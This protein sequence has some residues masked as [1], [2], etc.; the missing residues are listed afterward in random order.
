MRGIFLIYTFNLSSHWSH[1]YVASL[2]PFMIYLEIRGEIKSIL[3][4]L[5]W[6]GKCC[7]L[8]CLSVFHHIYTQ[9]EIK[10]ANSFKNKN[11]RPHE[12]FWKLMSIFPLLEKNN[13]LTRTS[14]I[15]QCKPSHIIWVLSK[16]W[17]ICW[18]KKR[19]NFLP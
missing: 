3:K 14:S 12:F 6:P 5:Q 11:L 15:L 16:Y 9:K 7:E 17:H 10:T 4:K 19:G 1:S 13:K 18:A 2:W 8:V